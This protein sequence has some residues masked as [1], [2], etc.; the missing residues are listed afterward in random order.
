MIYILEKW[1]ENK[2]KK[3]PHTSI[4][5]EIPGIVDISPPTTLSVKSRSFCTKQSWYQYKK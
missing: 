1:Q 4:A 3:F 5:S 2:E